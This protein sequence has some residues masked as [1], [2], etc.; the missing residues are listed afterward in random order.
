MGKYAIQDT[1]LQLIADAIRN[2]TGATG[3]MSP[4][5]MADA[6]N[7]ISIYTNTDLDG[8]ITRTAEVVESYTASSVAAYAFFNNVT[9][10]TVVL[11]AANTIEE[12]AF[13]DC[14]NLE[15]ISS[16]AVQIGAYAFCGCDELN[17]V[18]FSNEL[19]TIGVAAFDGCSSL[20][21]VNLRN[22][23]IYTIA[24]S[25]FAGS[26]LTELWLPEARICSLASVN[27]FSG[28]PIGVGGSGGVIYV[29]IR[30][31]VQY[32]ANTTW[33]KILGN[34]TNRVVTY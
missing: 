9:V 22:T 21:S 12:Y 13:C 28:S 33:A 15:R 3:V 19:R 7:S 14:V 34:G 27:S 5:E 23:S 18:L 11:P 32:E 4:A 17:E 1:T 26:G 29:P 30:F 20:T 31:R 8:M 16:G 6:I 24:P 25:A 10:R 2:K